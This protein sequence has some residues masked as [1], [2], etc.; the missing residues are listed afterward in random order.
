VRPVWFL[1]F[2]SM[3]SHTRFLE[4]GG[5]CIQRFLDYV[6]CVARFLVYVIEEALY[7]ARG[8]EK[9]FQE[10]LKGPVTQVGMSPPVHC[11]GGMELLEVE[12]VVA[13]L[14]GM[15]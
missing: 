13:G 9:A 12:V 14:L 7:L 11:T 2:A 15:A 4:H 1:L 6:S 10:G 3:R 8:A 5:S